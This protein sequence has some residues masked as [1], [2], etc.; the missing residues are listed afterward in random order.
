MRLFMPSMLLPLRPQARSTCRRLT[1]DDRTRVS[2]DA[3]CRGMTSFHHID[4]HEVVAS[5]G[6]AMNILLCYYS[7]GHQI[8]FF[9]V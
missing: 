7:V 4:F 6:Y 9:S 3:P 2:L 5:Q 1:Q 8:L